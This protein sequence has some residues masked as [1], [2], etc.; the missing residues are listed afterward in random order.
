MRQ[1]VMGSEGNQPMTDETEDSGKDPGI[2]PET[3]SGPAAARLLTLES[4][5][6]VQQLADEGFIEKAGRG[7]YYTLSVV[8][9]Y[10]RFLREKSQEKNQNQHAN[11]VADARAREIELRNAK[12]E[13]ET[14]EF[15]EAEAVFLELAGMLKSELT[16]LGAR[17]TRDMPMR[18]KI[19]AAIDD[20]F[21]RAAARTA[22]TLKALRETGEVVDTD[23]ED[24][25]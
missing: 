16:G 4:A 1:M 5:R 9:G 6:R 25:S 24:E 12:A 7:R 18:K 8:Q 15:V 21:S 23:A 22:E 10:I 20:V 2:Q 11:R 3:I 19:E 14:I 13:H 17:V